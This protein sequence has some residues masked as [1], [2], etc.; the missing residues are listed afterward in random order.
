[1]VFNLVKLTFVINI[2]KKIIGEVKDKAK[3]IKEGDEILKG[4]CLN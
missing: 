4:I 3:R 1:V 2:A